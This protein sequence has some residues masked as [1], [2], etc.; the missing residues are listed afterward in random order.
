M[1]SGYGPPEQRPDGRSLD[2]RGSEEQLL[3]HFWKV[4]TRQCS[5]Y[6]VAGQFELRLTSGG[7]L[8]RS[9]ICRDS[10][11]AA[12]LAREWLNERPTGKQ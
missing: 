9:A 6:R 11:H 2:V 3:R 8:V 10:G 1:T 5:L 7:A 12:T 4:G